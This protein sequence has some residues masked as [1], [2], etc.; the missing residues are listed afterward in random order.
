[1]STF[2]NTVTTT[3]SDPTSIKMVLVGDG[4]V[5]K[6]SLL[7]SYTTNTFPQEY[8]PTVFDNYVATVRC[9]DQL[10]KLWLW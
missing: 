1:M 4:N 6:T 5:G 10:I 7:I 2:C 9:D 8:V 3:P